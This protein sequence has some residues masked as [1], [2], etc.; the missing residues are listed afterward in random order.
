MHTSLECDDFD[1]SKRQ[2]ITRSA[3]PQMGEAKATASVQLPSCR[4]ETRGV[5]VTEF[6]VIGVV[7]IGRA[8]V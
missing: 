3:P 6:L 7:Q 4:I 8:H 1:V 5:Q 2:G